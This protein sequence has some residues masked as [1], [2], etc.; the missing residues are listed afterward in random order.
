MEIVGIH[1][2][3]DHFLDGLRH[4]YPDVLLPLCD[5]RAEREQP[6]VVLL[7]LERGI[8]RVGLIEPQQRRSDA[9]RPFL[10]AAERRAPDRLAGGVPGAQNG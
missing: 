8:A 2:A 6:R 7:D 10:E 3:I 9:M 5:H 4:T 1:R